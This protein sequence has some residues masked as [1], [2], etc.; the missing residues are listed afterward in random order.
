MPWQ[1]NIGREHCEWFGNT[2][3]HHCGRYAST[4][5]DIVPSRI[6]RTSWAS[7]YEHLDTTSPSSR[8]GSSAV[9][10]GELSWGIL[11]TFNFVKYMSSCHDSWPLDMKASQCK[12]NCLYWE[13]YVAENFFCTERTHFKPQD[14]KMHEI[15]LLFNMSFIEI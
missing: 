3:Y 12:G 13:F 8:Q 14:D 9:N 15:Y 1:T 4:T 5:C 6:R 10:D 11:V 7:R 2:G